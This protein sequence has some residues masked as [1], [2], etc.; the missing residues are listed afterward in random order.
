VLRTLN[1]PPLVQ[2]EAMNAEETLIAHFGVGGAV[3]NAGTEP[4]GQLP[5]RPLGQLANRR[6]E[7]DVFR[8]DY[9]SRLTI[10]QYVLA[11]NSPVGGT[12]TATYRPYTPAYYTFNKSCPGYQSAVAP[13][14][15]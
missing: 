12:P 8:L 3:R 11:L 15:S 4:P 6:H 1:L 7:I 10:G 13:P 9:C 14:T 2:T 5:G